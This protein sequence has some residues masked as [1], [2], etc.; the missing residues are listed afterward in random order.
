MKL[1]N[2]RKIR[3]DN[4]LTQEYVAAKLQIAQRTYSHYENG[5][6]NIPTQMLV[7]LSNYYEVSTDYLLGLT[8][9]P[10]RFYVLNNQKEKVK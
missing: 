10:T 1:N 5:T 3:E 4:D 9:I 8:N 7:V 2:L 6:R